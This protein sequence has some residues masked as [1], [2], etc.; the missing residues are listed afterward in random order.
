MQNVGVVVGAYPRIGLGYELVILLERVD[1]NV[2]QG[3]YH[4]HTQKEYGGQ[5][6]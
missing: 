6:I 2:D 5:K 4:K 3:I 1:E